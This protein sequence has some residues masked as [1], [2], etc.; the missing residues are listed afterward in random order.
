MEFEFAAI[1]RNEKYS[2]N[3]VTNDTLI[4]NKTGEELRKQGCGFKI[5]DE[6]ELNGDFVEE[7]YIFS[8]ARGEESIEKLQKMNEAG[9]F[10]INPPASILNCYRVNLSVILPDAGID[11]PPSMIV[12]TAADDSYR[13]KDITE[14]NKLWIK[15]GDVH[16][17]HKEDVS[18]V[19]YDEEIN[20]LLKE[21]N[22]RG[23]KKA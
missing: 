23:M 15:R 18:L 11:F 12:A 17:I 1:K 8:M 4:L 7:E 22:H 13:L 6:Y 19:Y 16:A 20:Y 21:F 2:P 5:Y 3:H 14:K 9:K 10:I